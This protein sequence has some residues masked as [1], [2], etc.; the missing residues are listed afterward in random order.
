MA[1]SWVCLLGP[2]DDLLDNLV[3][4]LKKTYSPGNENVHSEGIPTVHESRQER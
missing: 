4:S 1:F 3:S 2:K